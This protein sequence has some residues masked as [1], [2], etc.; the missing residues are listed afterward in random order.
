MKAMSMVKRG[1]LSVSASIMSSLGAPRRRQARLVP[2]LTRTAFLASIPPARSVLEL[3]PFDVPLMHGAGVAYF[4]VL[5]QEGLRRRAV[6]EGRNPD[7]CPKIDH[8]S[9]NGD[10]MVI[11][12]R[13]DQVFSS[14]VVEHQH[15]LI[16]HLVDVAGLLNDDGLY[17]VIVPDKRYC[18]DHFVPESSLDDVIDAAD[19]GPARRVERAIEHVH[20]DMAH[21]SALK[22][23]VGLHGQ[24][25]TAGE[26]AQQALADDLSRYRAGEYRDVHASKFTPGSF[27]AITDALYRSGRSPL[28]PLAVYDTRVGEQEFYAILAKSE[29]LSSFAKV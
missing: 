21:N 26:G 12:D 5:D 2:P 10:L 16:R 22:H 19:R 3:G 20:F 24:R 11:R 4:D 9:P 28:K 15:D 7:G 1:A 23:W 13:F 8:V 14:H 18:F 29:P 27:M 17:C 6:Q 25:I